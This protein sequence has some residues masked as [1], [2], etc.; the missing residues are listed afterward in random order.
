ML[1]RQKCPESAQ[2][3]HGVCAE[4]KKMNVEASPRENKK[5]MHRSN[6]LRR[7]GFVGVFSNKLKTRSTQIMTKNCTK[8]AYAVIQRI[9]LSTNQSPKTPTKQEL[10]GSQIH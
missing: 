8:R 1:S 2:T 9:Y 6:F 5:P 3:S 7:M 4:G 10:E